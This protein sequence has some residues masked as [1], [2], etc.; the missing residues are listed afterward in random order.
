MAIL[1]CNE[2]LHR[3]DEQHS[4]LRTSAI[5]SRAEKPSEDIAR[6]LFLMNMKGLMMISPFALPRGCFLYDKY[7]SSHIFFIFFA[8]NKEYKEERQN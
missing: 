3:L 1:I 2:F 4:P 7:S 6:R 8:K 5:F